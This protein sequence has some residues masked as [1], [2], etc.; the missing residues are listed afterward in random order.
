M[1][2]L[3]QFYIET[4]KL[5]YIAQDEAKKSLMSHISDI[6]E[7]E[8]ERSD[9]GASEGNSPKTTSRAD[10]LLQNDSGESPLTKSLAPIRTISELELETKELRFEEKA[11]QAD[12]IEAETAVL[13]KEQEKPLLVQAISSHDS[14]RSIKR[15]TAHTSAPK[16][17]FVAGLFRRSKHFKKATSL[18]AALGFEPAGHESWRK[19][20]AE[21]RHTLD[22]SQRPPNNEE[23]EPSE[24]IR[25][26]SRQ[27]PLSPKREKNYSNIKNQYL[28]R[29]SQ[30]LRQKDF[31]GDR[32]H[33]QT[34]AA[35]VSEM[36][37]PVRSLQS[38]FRPQLN[39]SSETITK[40]RNRQSLQSI[41]ERSNKHQYSKFS[42][43]NTYKNPKDR[44]THPERFS[45]SRRLSLPKNEPDSKPTERPF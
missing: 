31:F 13:V 19:A 14:E 28:K 9:F 17:D 15:I 29:H 16:S 7:V 26:S 44:L 25:S 5:N 37:L 30:G 22:E 2:Q 27:Q 3:F 33:P 20:L 10:A 34:H 11:P 41:L 6:P 12:R 43:M 42:I 4:N 23:K 21:K 1:D 35:N 38:P 39:S 40:N 24:P 45:G 8:E 36:H 18:H 32:L